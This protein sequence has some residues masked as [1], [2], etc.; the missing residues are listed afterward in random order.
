MELNASQPWVQE[1]AEAHLKKINETL[2][3]I[4]GKLKKQIDKIYNLNSK[5]VEVDFINQPEV[6]ELLKK[7]PV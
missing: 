4:H 3:W 2:E 7:V 1:K 6:Q 5:N